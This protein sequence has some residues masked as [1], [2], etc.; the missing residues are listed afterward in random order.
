MALMVLGAIVKGTSSLVMQI[1]L[2]RR[3]KTTTILVCFGAL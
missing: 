2:I 1:I 3:L